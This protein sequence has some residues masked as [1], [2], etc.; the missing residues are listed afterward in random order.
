[1]ITT[2][3]LLIIAYLLL[4]LFLQRH[5]MKCLRIKAN[6]PKEVPEK[7]LNPTSILGATKRQ[8]L[9]LSDK[10]RQISKAVPKSSKFA[11]NNEQE[12]T[13]NSTEQEEIFPMGKPI[14]SEEQEELNAMFAEK[15]VSEDDISLT[16]KELQI[17]HNYLKKPTKEQE[18]EA[19]TTYQKVET[20][21]FAP[22]LV[23]RYSENSVNTIKE[24]Q[25]KILEMEKQAVQEKEQATIPKEQHPPQATKTAVSKEDS[26]FDIYKCINP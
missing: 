17:L 2:L 18:K 12:T 16:Q 14:P 21:E 9:T 1:M 5:D 6:P 8:E 26:D 25:W 20:T 4:L 15:E 11:K 7:I 23:A 19:F 13:A 10:K 24:W 22:Q 3:L